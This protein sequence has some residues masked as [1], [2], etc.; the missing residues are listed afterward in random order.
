[1]AQEQVKRQTEQISGVSNVAYDLLATLY[2]KLEG[3]AALE[4]YKMDAQGSG[5]QDVV[6][7]F[8][9]LEQRDRQDVDQLRQMLIQRMK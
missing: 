7:F 9:Q 8:D 5:D 2:N 3:I 1:M 6:K 4:E